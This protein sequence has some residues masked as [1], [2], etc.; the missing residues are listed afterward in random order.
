MADSLWTWKIW[1]GVLEKGREEME[2][3]R[4]VPRVGVARSSV[5]VMSNFSLDF[6]DR[7]PDLTCQLA[8]SGLGLKVYSR[9]VVLSIRT[10]RL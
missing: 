9:Q 4:E 7:D 1:P 2:G 3:W 5:W 8:S 6:V 10:I